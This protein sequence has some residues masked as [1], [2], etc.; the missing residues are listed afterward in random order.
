MLLSELSTSHNHWPQIWWKRLWYCD[1]LTKC[2]TGTWN[3]LMPSEKMVPIDLQGCHTPSV[4]L[5]MQYLQSAIQQSTIKW[6]MHRLYYPS[7]IYLVITIYPVFSS[8]DSN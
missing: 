1:K 3:E 7:M 8:D 5:K 4:C 2:D 6:S